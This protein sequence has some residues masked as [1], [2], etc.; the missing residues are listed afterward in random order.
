MSQATAGEL[1]ALIPSHVA[2]LCAVMAIAVAGQDPKWNSQTIEYV[3]TELDP[4][5]EIL[6]EHGVPDP[7]ANSTDGKTELFWGRVYGSSED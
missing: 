3:L 4:V 5:L 7:Y 6:R 1:A 2:Q